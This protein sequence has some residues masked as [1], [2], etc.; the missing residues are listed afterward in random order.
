VLL[1]GG[2]YFAAATLLKIREL[3]LIINLLHRF[4]PA[5]FRR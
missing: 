5:R 4:L 2:V 1:G 3:N